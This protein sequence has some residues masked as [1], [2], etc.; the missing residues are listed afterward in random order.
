MINTPQEEDSKINSLIN[1]PQEWQ[2][3]LN[4]QNKHS[5]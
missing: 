5:D 4:K 2:N 3:K 1:T